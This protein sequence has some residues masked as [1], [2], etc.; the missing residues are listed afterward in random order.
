MASRKRKTRE[1]K[2]LALR[3]Q[4]LKRVYK[5]SLLFNEPEMDA[6][7]NFCRR[8]KIANKSKFFRETIITTI[9]KKIEKDHPTLF[10]GF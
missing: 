6:I 1:I 2:M 10:D 4:H 7:N 9:L 5:K 8:Y 3:E